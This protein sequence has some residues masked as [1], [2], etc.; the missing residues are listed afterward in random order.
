MLRVFEAE[1]IGYLADRQAGLDEQLLGAFDDGILDVALG[2]STA[3]LANQVA[4]VV[5]RQT[6]LVGKVSYGGQ[7]VPFWM[8]TH[9]VFAQLLMESGEDVAVHLV[10]RD[11]LA[12]VVTNNQCVTT[13][14]PTQN[15]LSDAESNICK[16]NPL[17][18]NDIT[19][20]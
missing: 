15:L 4:E 8:A 1:L 13:Y 10:A 19:L 9:E 17:I 6:G 16:Y 2:G 7:T 20:F 3:F 5:G 12:V 18:D 11:E 14:L